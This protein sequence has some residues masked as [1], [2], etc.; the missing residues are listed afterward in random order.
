VVDPKKLLLTRKHL[1]GVKELHGVQS[2]WARAGDFFLSFILC[3]TLIWLLNSTILWR[4]F[5]VLEFP[6][7]S[8]FELGG[9]SQIGCHHRVCR[10]ALAE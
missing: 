9:R 3:N 10:A 2:E 7:R 8:H 4:S 6:S 1:N 5:L